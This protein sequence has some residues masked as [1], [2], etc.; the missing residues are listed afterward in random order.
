M[1]GGEGRGRVLEGEGVYGQGLPEE[2][3]GR[4]LKKKISFYYNT[5]HSRCCF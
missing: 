3:E 4:D 5:E 2:R 1:D